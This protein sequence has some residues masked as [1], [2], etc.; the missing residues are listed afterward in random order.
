MAA[1]NGQPRPWP[2]DYRIA[3]FSR[4][5]RHAREHPDLL[6]RPGRAGR[7]S[8]QG[9]QRP[10]HAAGRR[11]PDVPRRL[12]PPVPQRRRLAAGA[13]SRKR[14]LQPAA[15]P[16]DA[17]RDGTP[18]LVSVPLPGR[19]VW[20]RVWRIQVGRVP[21]YLLDTNIPQNNAGRPQITAR[22]YG[23]D[24]T[25]ASARKWSW[26]SAASAPCGPWA[27]RRPSAT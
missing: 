8:P 9:G 18:L 3:Y 26:A 5:V 13:L 12:F 17:S 1:S 7:R 6:R 16:R 27:R 23:G 20:C 2:S 15:D 19:E 11:R 24:T 14:L 4:R 21:L 25:C 22:L 10:R